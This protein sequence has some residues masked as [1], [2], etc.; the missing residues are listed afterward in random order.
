MTTQTLTMA[1]HQAI[2]GASRV[3]AGSPACPAA[4]HAAAPA[5]LVGPAYGHLTTS[6][7]VDAAAKTTFSMVFD[8]KDRP[9]RQPSEH[10]P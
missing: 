7:N 5:A 6:W 1:G 4:P 10:S 2:A 3:R 8:G 9:T